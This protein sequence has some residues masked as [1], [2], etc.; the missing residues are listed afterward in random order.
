L[1]KYDFHDT[2]P[3]SK[4]N[5]PMAFLRALI[6]GALLSPSLFVQQLYSAESATQRALSL[7]LVIGLTA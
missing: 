4:S 3:Q 7:A 5:R 1:L 6:A 2:P